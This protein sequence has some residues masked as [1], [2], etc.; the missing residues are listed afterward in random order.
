MECSPCSL[1]SCVWIPSVRSV[2]P[3]VRSVAPRVYLAKV[4][5]LG[6]FIYLFIYFIYLL[7]LFFNF[8]YFILFFNTGRSVAID[9]LKLVPW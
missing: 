7:L 1:I 6:L 8:I 5:L 2:A 4:P 3:S 9:I